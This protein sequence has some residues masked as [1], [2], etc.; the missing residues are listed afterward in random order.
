MSSPKSITRLL[1]DWHLGDASAMDKLMPLVYDE[2]HYLA[3]VYLRREPAGHTLQPTAL[4]HEAYL[5]L[6]DQQDVEWQ[7]RVHFF[8][9]AARLMRQILVDHARR[10]H[11]TRRG[12]GWQK[13]TLD[14]AINIF[15]E[16]DVNLIRLDDALITLEKFDP[17]ASH[18]VELR[19]FGGLTI[20]EVAEVLNLSV[21]TTNR[22]W[23][24]S[25]LWLLREIGGE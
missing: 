6:V 20:E 18:I 8:G 11:A 13:V 17:R 25:K 19:F 4:V 7:N 22:E 2:L 24:A 12:G 23:R 15:K 10:Q 5:R 14:E 16:R 3:A 1:L 21:A 9:V